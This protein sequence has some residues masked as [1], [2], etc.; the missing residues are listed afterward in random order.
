MV[1][2][3]LYR[4]PF[5]GHTTGDRPTRAGDIG[6][7]VTASILASVTQVSTWHTGLS[8]LCEVLGTALGQ[9]LPAQTGDTVRS[10]DRLVMQ[11]GPEEFLII[12]NEAA[13]M[14]ALLRQSI[15]ADVGSVTNLSHARCRIHLE[16]PKCVD[17]LSK[18][19]PIDLR[20]H[21]FAHGQIRLTG[22]HH[23]PSLLHRLGAQSFDVY[24]FS[25]YAFDQL[26]AV[27]DAAREYGVTLKSTG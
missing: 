6:V 27:L 14:T 22:H 13:D 25:T 21:A 11:T 26:A 7:T 3:S 8:A 20:D 16:G 12:S 23:V 4:S 17:T 19:F 18:L 1:K 9:A 5:E 10:K 24:V 2:S 15:P